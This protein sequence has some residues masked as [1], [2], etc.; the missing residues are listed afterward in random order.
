[1]RGRK[2]AALGSRFSVFLQYV[3]RSEKDCDRA[4]VRLLDVRSSEC[5][6]GSWR[7]LQVG[8]LT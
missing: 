3:R 4:S 7:Y 5:W 6:C 1:M 8:V 2:Q